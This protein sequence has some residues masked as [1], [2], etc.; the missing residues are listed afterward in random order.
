MTAGLALVIKLVS[1]INDAE[2]KLFAIAAAM[3]A[4]GAAIL[5]IAA[6]MSLITTFS[7]DD[8]TGVI[9]LFGAFIVAII[10]VAAAI[11]ALAHFDPTGNTLKGFTV[12]ILAL[13]AAFAL[14]GVGVLAAAAGF[15][16]LTQIGGKVANVIQ[17]I[18]AALAEHPAILT[19][20]VILIV[21]VAVAIALIV[22]KATE[23]AT[24]IVKVVDKIWEV[25]SKVGEKI[26]KFFND[27]I[28]GENGLLKK[29]KDKFLALSP[30]LKTI[31]ISTLTTVLAVI[32][33]MTPKALEVLGYVIKKV[34]GFI[35]DLIPTLVDGLFSIVLRLLNGLADKIREES[36]II[37][38]TIYNILEALFEVIIDMF[39]EIGAGFWKMLGF[40]DFAEDMVDAGT[41]FKDKLRNGLAGMQEYAIEVNKIADVNSRVDGTLFEI[42]DS[43][44]SVGNEAEASAEKT[45]LWNDQ[46]EDS[47]DLMNRLNDGSITARESIKDIPAVA[48]E[49]MIH[50]GA[51][52]RLKDK[53]GN[54][55]FKAFDK[56]GETAGDGLLGGLGDTIS[57]GMPNISNP[58]DMVKNVVPEG[59]DVAMNEEGIDYGESFAE[60]EETGLEDPNGYAEAEQKNMDAVN[61]TVEKNKRQHKEAIKTNIVDPGVGIITNSRADYEA[62][63]RY[64][65]EGA[66]AGVRDTRDAF[67]REMQITAQLGLGSFVGPRGLDENSPS[68]KMYDAGVYAILGFVNA[69]RKNGDMTTDSMAVMGGNGVEG[70][71]NALTSNGYLVSDAAGG[72]SNSI[73]NSF[74]NPMGYVARM[75]SG[76]LAYDPTIRPVLDTST[77]AR[78]AYGINSMFSNQNV[79]LAGLS[80]QLAADI[81]QLD[82]RNNDIV[83][84]LKA[85]REEMSYLSD[86][87]QNMQVVMDTGA[88]VG[89]MAGPMDKAMG[90]RAIYKGRG[91]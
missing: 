76:E 8:L 32:V 23:L 24:A 90:R 6:A 46:I 28:L 83:A 12:L 53:D 3:I 13:G 43:F 41:L 11:A 9:V 42:S 2:K 55:I 63:A 91:N 27:K 79:T 59:T 75:A 17:S 51:G 82:S 38:Y 52:F 49:A 61:E 80:G 35:I 34:I 45:K 57:E 16:V 14:V 5:L 56:V 33:M 68:K 87:M 47:T 64:A 10:V 22:V 71:A 50:A 54:E 36:A 31:M 44:K 19:L 60:G 39:M 37:A 40:D 20:M 21:A 67:V 1:G 77:I 89:S 25:I 73:I 30:T 4:M 18:G 66:V 74:G 88:L 85:L 48:Q 84:E 29:I 81:G 15:Y 78:G 58:E 70:L 7:K 62:A 26:G 86:D 69:I 65:T 72:L